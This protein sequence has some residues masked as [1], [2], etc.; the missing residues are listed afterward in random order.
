[1]TRI[2]QL[3]QFIAEDPKD[4]F[5]QYGLA[6]EYLH[7]EPRLA[8]ESFESLLTLFPDYLPTYYPAAQLLLELD[9]IQKAET[10]FQQGI[11]LAAK[12]GD[13]KTETELKQ[14]YNQWLY[15]R[16]AP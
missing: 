15:E 13:R 4:P 7:H 9:Q 6:L 3:K 11:T 16:E 10:I 12:Q 1:M 14:A 5:L 2:D 8:L